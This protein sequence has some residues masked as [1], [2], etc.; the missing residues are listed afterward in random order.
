MFIHTR[1]ATIMLAIGGSWVPQVYVSFMQGTRYHVARTKTTGVFF[2][3]SEAMGHG[4]AKHFLL[5]FAIRF[6]ADHYFVNS[7]GALETLTPRDH[8]G[9]FH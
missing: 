5:G 4:K 6:L 1:G 9:K 3:D 8:Q 7:A 2:P